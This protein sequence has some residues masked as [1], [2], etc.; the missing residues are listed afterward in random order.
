MD[1]PKS[2]DEWDKN[3]RITFSS[4][5]GVGC[6]LLPTVMECESKCGLHF[7]HTYRGHRLL[8]DCF[9]DFFLETIALTTERIQ[10]NG[11]PKDSPFF[12]V[13]LQSFLT[14]FRSF[15]AAE[16]LSVNGYPFDGY[17]LQRNLMEEAFAFGAIVGGLSTFP[18]RLG[19][20]EFPKAGGGPED[21]KRAAK[22]RENEERRIQKLMIGSDSGLADDHCAELDRWDKMF[23]QQVHGSRFSYYGESGRWFW[24]PGEALS[25]G[26]RPDETA[27]AMYMNRCSEIAWLTLRVLPFLQAPGGRFDSIWRR[28]W[29]ILDVSFRYG[30]LELVK[31]EKKI[32]AAIIALVDQKYPFSPDTQY[33]ERI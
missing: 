19:V 26:P 31:M 33:E 8:I 22:R 4:E 32:A 11:W 3:L 15:R 17:A 9:Q 10:K 7:V 30:T 20:D 25:L 2:G 23:D 16:V 14:H 29:H 1:I 6:Q 21:L 24:Q 27:S 13:C 18:K 12:R 5:Q 28:K